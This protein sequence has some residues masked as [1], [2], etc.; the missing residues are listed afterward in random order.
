VPIE[1]EIKARVRDPQRLIAALEGH[2]TGERSTY[3][4]RYFDLP[5]RRWTRDGHELRV[6]TVV[7]ESGAARTVLTFKEPAVD[8]ATAS[9]PEH[10]T[11]VD[12]PDV[13][14]TVLAAL[15]AEEIIAFEKRCLNYRLNAQG[16]ELLATIVTVPELGEETFLELETRAAERD[17]EAALSVV[18]SVLAELGIPPEDFTTEQYTEAVAARRGQD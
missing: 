10:E 2:S 9:K 16:R 5:D 14:V 1:A 6:R 8:P 11:T 15:G 3:H 4:D 18:R 7:A 12:D 13:L 17:T